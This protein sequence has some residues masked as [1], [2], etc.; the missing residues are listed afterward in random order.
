M[1]KDGF[2]DDRI[3]DFE[4]GVEGDVIDLSGVEGITKF[5]DLRTDHLS[6][7]GGDAIISDGAGNTAILINIDLEEL[8]KK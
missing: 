4:L 2:G 1:F 8:H 6:S 3:H 5:Y 7:E